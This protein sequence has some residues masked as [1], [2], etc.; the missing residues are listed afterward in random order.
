MK[1]L[2]FQ[3]H[4]FHQVNQR[5]NETFGYLGNETF[6]GLQVNVCHDFLQLPPVKGLPV[7]ISAASIKGF[8]PLDLWRIFQMVELTDVMLQRGDFEFISLLNKIR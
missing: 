2:W 5:L 1:F 8:I 6:A 7:Y 4:F 3:V